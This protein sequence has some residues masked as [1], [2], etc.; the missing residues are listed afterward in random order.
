MSDLKVRTHG[1]TVV[2]I[3]WSNRGH[4]LTLDTRLESP[5]FFQRYK[6]DFKKHGRDCPDQQP[7]RRTDRLPIRPLPEEVIS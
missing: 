2:V 1:S 4:F 7:D 3:G 5:S 6:E